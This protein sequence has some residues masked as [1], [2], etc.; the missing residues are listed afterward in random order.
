VKPF[1]QTFFKMA[2]TP[3]E[4]P[5]HRRSR[6][7]FWRSRSSAKQTLSTFQ[8]RNGSSVSSKSPLF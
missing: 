4:K 8:Q 5:F 2:P 7:H 6:S 3:S 1:C